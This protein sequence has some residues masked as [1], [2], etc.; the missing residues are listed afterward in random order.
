MRHLRAYATAAVAVVVFVFTWFFRFNDPNGGFAGLTDDHFYYLLRG[1]QILYGELPFRDF[2]DA[3]APLYFY[4]SAAVQMVIGRGTLSELAFSTT[5]LALG[6]ALTFWLAA[7]ASGSIVLGIVGA[8]FE[9]LLLPRF[10]NYPKILVYTAA[11]PLLWWYVDRPVRGPVIWL[12]VVTVF[13][14]L[15][16]HDHGAFVA[17]AT[18]AMLVMAT[19]LPWRD[20]IR[21][22]VLYA[23]VSIALVSPYLLFVQMNGGLDAYRRQAAEWVAEERART[24]VQWPGL[25]DNADGV[26]SEA[27]D[28]GGLQRAVAIV[29]DNRVAWL[30]YFEIVLPLLALGVAG[31][32]RDGFRPEWP[33][34][35]QKIAIVALVGLILDAGFLRS[36]LQARV[37]DPSVPHAIL[38]AWLGTALIGIL[39]G[40]APLRPAVQRRV[41]VVRAAAVTIGAGV[42][43]L[44]AAIFS[45][46]IYDRLEDA[47]L[48]EGPRVALARVRT[49]SQAARTDWDLSTW[50]NRED[51]SGLM[52]L[53]LYLN[54]CTPPDARIFVQPYL[55]QVLG[56]AQ[57]GF[58]AGFGDLRP[59]FFDEPEFERLALRRLR[60]QRV[61]VALLDVDES[62][63]NFRESFPLLTSYF[64]AT[65]E[66]VATHTFDDRFGVTLLIRR[67]EKKHGQFEPLNWPCMS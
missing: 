9:I 10:Y 54:T 5:L 46:R 4:V 67:G 29:R 2:V 31:L 64:D 56:M 1:W 42:V 34:A 37:A 49:V 22:A 39:S 38:I 25:F 17:A 51:R 7:R 58:A 66:T 41:A 15:L 44:L 12:A 35:T 28:G 43:F 60:T 8:L 30:Y 53:A 13:G 24:P 40:R 21:S 47:Y 11:I 65:Y 48:T 61:P 59:G 32:A 50:I 18:A 45:D 19:H 63:E 62:L 3:G 52:T 55:P 6:A 26:S 16:R 14:F 20:R 36:P 27:R 33:H 23:V 57:R